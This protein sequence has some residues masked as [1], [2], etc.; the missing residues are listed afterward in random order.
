MAQER[1][2]PISCQGIHKFDQYNLKN[3][4]QKQK[5]YSNLIQGRLYPAANK[6]QYS[7][8]HGSSLMFPAA[9]E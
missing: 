4:P 9:V 3:Q 7:T 2:N 8:T 5:W 1:S 6:R